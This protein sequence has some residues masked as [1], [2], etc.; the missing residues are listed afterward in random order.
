MYITA[1]AFLL[2]YYVFIHI[3]LLKYR[4]LIVFNILAITRLDP[5][6]WWIF[7][8][9][10]LIPKIRVREG[11]GWEGEGAE[12]DRDRMPDLLLSTRRRS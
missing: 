3:C 1:R 2:S 9:K 8:G 12:V 10:F 4:E 6:I 7:A 5:K 11:E